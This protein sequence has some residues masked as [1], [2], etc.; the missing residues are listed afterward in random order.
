MKLISKINENSKK[1]LI[2][3]NKNFN[4]DLNFLKSLNLNDLKN[5]LKC[6]IIPLLKT[7]IQNYLFT[8]IGCILYLMILYG[9]NKIILIIGIIFPASVCLMLIQF[10]GLCIFAYL[11]GEDKIKP[12][13]KLINI[14]CG[15]ALRW[16]GICFTP[17]FVTLPLADKVSVAEGFKIAAVFVIGYIIMTAFVT[18]LVWGLQILLGSYTHHN[19]P[20]GQ[21]DEEKNCESD[22][23]DNEDN[24]LEDLKDLERCI[25][26]SSIS[27]NIHHI[28]SID[29]EN[30]LSIM[31]T[32]TDLSRCLTRQS[33]HHNQPHIHN[34]SHNTLNQHIQSEIPSNTQEIDN[35]HNYKATSKFIPNSAPETTGNNDDN[36]VLSTDY[37]KSI[38]TSIQSY[39]PEIITNYNNINNTNTTMKVT[40]ENEIN[41]ILSVAS[42]PPPSSD[43][44]TSNS[45][46]SN[47]P[48]EE[49]I[50]NYIIRNLDWILYSIFF[51]VSIPIYFTT[52][53]A[54]PYQLSV[55]VLLFKACLLLPNKC[56]R[57]L[58]PILLSFALILLVIFIMTSIKNTNFKNA[59]KLYKTG[60]NYSNLFNNKNYPN[61][62]G[63]GDFLL[64]LMDISI[65]SLSLPMFN[66]RLDLKKYFIVII[67]PIL[68]CSFGCLFIYPVVCY[69]IGISPERSL[70]FSGRSVTLAL[71]TPLVEALDGSVQ[72]MAVTTIVTGILGVLCGDFVLFKILRV[73]K[74]D[75]VTRGVCLGINCSA[76][77]TSYLLTVA[78]RAAAI[79]SLSFS[80]Y[81]TV[82]VIL[83]AIRPIVH[84]VQRLVGW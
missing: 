63:A 51:L 50:K 76:V 19:T 15:F 18:Y 68:C 5:S 80:L 47:E 52:N 56:K 67:V 53:Y 46:D 22:D 72:L 60:R 36:S 65:V 40:S 33:H 4:N 14:P 78:P 31:A 7:F 54:M 83:T 6:L 69:H 1:F 66:Y 12:F 28:D 30:A 57:I 21:D 39:R 13:I 73:H 27:T 35:K 43:N 8:A 75:F 34:H 77:S 41:S 64:S 32:N 24:N 42:T 61:W 3:L 71:G 16:M 29:D 38:N 48:K 59:I 23:N 44:T 17:A 37:D 9:I 84:I 10:I 20:T 74:N 25:S 11:L 79:S 2:N 58:H 62:P 81:G 82:M 45:N 49:I 70:G 55:S 26:T